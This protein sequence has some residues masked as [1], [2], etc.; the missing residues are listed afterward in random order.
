MSIKTIL[1]K[2]KTLVA[3]TAFSTFASCNL[4]T[5]T[6]IEER[7]IA[8]C[9]N[10]KIAEFEFVLNI[11]QIDQKRIVWVLEKNFHDDVGHVDSLLLLMKIC[12]ELDSMSVAM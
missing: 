8:V 5:D 11:F 7:D 1:F 12:L 6:V 2:I 4:P 9:S 10:E 3:Y